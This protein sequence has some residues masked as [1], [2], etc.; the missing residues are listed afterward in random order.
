MKKIIQQ[1]AEAI[2]YVEDG[3]LIKERIK[4]GYRIKEIDDSLRKLRTRKETKLLEKAKIIDVPEVYESSDKN[5][6]I[7]MEYLGGDLIKDILDGLDKEKRK[8]ICKNIG[9]NIVILHD[10]DIIHGD[11]TTSNMI[12][13]KDKVYF[14]DFGL[15]FISD[16]VEDKA[17]DLH[18]LK[19]ALMAK[20]YKILEETFEN[21]LKGYKEN[22][23][24]KEVLN[25]LEKVESRGRYKRKAK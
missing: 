11:L 18:L 21:V 23:N 15:G 1:G 4:K 14:I 10:N 13:K 12:L 7:V 8:T 24:F 5:M 9:K 6:K 16:K 22:K 19:K 2:L 3:K 20:H 17:V 25:R